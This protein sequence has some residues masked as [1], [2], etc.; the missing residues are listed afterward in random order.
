VA[1][2]LNDWNIGLPFQIMQKHDKFGWWV[3]IDCAYFLLQWF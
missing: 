3:G 1:I 2:N